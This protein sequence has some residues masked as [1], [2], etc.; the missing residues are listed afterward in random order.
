M[1]LWFAVA[2]KAM[3]LRRKTTDEYAQTFEP[4]VLHKMKVGEI[5]LPEPD[6]FK[7]Y[8]AEEDIADLP[9]R[10]KK[11][12][13]ALS[14]FEQWLDWA[15][16]EHIKTNRH[17][18]NLEAEVIRRGMELQKIR[19]SHKDFVWQYAVMKWL[20]LTVGA[21]LVAASIKIGMENFAK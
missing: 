11:T 19:D 6:T 15:L 12:V 21:G 2:R 1:G 17:L 18:R 3:P 7:G 13:I 5:H 16:H 4:E 14:I 20:G 8:I 9:K 10:D